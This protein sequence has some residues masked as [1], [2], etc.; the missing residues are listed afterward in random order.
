MQEPVK[1]KYYSRRSRSLLIYDTGTAK[2][3]RKIQVVYRLILIAVFLGFLMTGAG[4]QARVREEFY[5]FN[6]DGYTSALKEREFMRLAVQKN[7]S[8]TALLSG[9]ERDPRDAQVQFDFGVVHELGQGAPQDYK[10]A[11]M[12]YRMAAEQGHADAQNN[13]GWL[14]ENG[15]GV[16][17][18]FSEAVSWYLEAAEQGHADAQFNLGVMYYGGRGVVQDLVQAYMWFGLSEKTVG[19]EASNNRK[20]VEV[21]MTPE[22]IEEAQKLIWKLS[23]KNRK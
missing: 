18:D 7:F 6:R 11:A 13:L 1:L 21:E 15:K 10:K 14:Y 20:L 5:I 22:Q 12:W 19:L 17:Q 23:R 2:M 9:V 3:I 8:G 16:P 4:A